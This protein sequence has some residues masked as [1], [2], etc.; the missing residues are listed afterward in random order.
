MT[1]KELILQQ[2]LILFAQKGY[3]GVSVREI[4]AAV[5]VRASA[6]YK[7][8]ANKEAI[9]QKVI[10][11]SLHR[12]HEAYEENQVPE[13]VHSE[14]IAGGYRALSDEAV[15]EITWNLF[16]LYTKDE[17]VSNFRKLVMREQYT[18]PYIAKA[19]NDVFLQ[20]ALE[21]QSK[22]FLALIMGDMFINVDPKVIALEFYGPIF[23]LFQIYDLDP[24]K[25]ESI[26]EMIYGHV[27]TFG[28]RFA[29]KV[30]EDSI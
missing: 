12:I 26:R 27:K 6:L 9:F 4:A 20:G 19:Y 29:A 18:H 24:T 5:G 8:F 10:E 28:A 22:T 11:E 25:E 14:D 13:T 1:T 15:C 2:S 7:H 30:S 23:L 21:F 16:K 3:D 17:M